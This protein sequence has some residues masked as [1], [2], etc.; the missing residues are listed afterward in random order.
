[1]ISFCTT[2]RNGWFQGSGGG[3]E[4]T[5]LSER[6]HHCRVTES[7]CLRLSHGRASSHAKQTETRAYVFKVLRSFSRNTAAARTRGRR[8]ETGSARVL[9]LTCSLGS[10]CSLTAISLRPQTRQAYVPRCLAAVSFTHSYSRR[11][12]AVSTAVGCPRRPIK[13][14]GM[15]SGLV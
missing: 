11:A 7:T 15:N 14:H 9:G 13:H 2:F 10:V 5:H 1:M 6:W 12:S 8:L 4:R 3:A